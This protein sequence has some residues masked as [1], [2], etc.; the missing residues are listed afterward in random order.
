MTWH[1]GDRS[2]PDAAAPERELDRVHV[3]RERTSSPPRESGSWRGEQSVT[4]PHW[5]SRRSEWG[6]RFVEFSVHQSTPYL[7][8]RCPLTPKP[9]RATYV[10]LAFATRFARSL[11]TSFGDRPVSRAKL[12]ICRARRDLSGV[13]STVSIR[14]RRDPSRLGQRA[15]SVLDRQPDTCPARGS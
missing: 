6:V 12:D 11:I 14:G 1:Q 7:R 9:C 8:L 15:K 2:M 3:P 13:G 5:E 10:A 4:S